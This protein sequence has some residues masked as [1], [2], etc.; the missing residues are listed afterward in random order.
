M[1]QAALPDSHPGAGD[2]ASS[3]PE[4]VQQKEKPPTHEELDP[5]LR[6]KKTF[7]SPLPQSVSSHPSGKGGGGF[8]LN[9]QG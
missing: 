6:G 5:S 9:G 3:D 4:K 8:I 1:P 2:P 7:E